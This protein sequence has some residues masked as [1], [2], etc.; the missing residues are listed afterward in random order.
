MNREGP[1]T[2]AE[3]TEQLSPIS[4]LRGR[5]LSFPT[6]A[7]VA[8][9]G[10]LLALVLVRFFD[11]DWGEVW[12]DVRSTRPGPYLLALALY[13]TSFWF[14]GLRWRLI[15]RTAGLE[16][17]SSAEVPRT[18]TMS[19]IILMG[20]F[21]N[22]VAFL[23]LGDA[24]R[25]WA[26][27]RESK[28]GVSASLGTVLAERVQDMAA[29]LVL[30][31]V[32][33]ALLASDPAVEA[34]VSVVIAAVALVAALIAGLIVMRTFGMRLARWLPGRLQ[35]SYAGFQSG[36]LQSFHPR[37]LP[38]QLALGAAGWMLEIARLYYVAEGVGVELSFGVIMFAALANAMLTTIPTPGGFGFVESGLTGLL[39]FFGLDNT[40]AFS[41]TLVD[42]TI[43]W[44]SVVIFGGLLFFYWHFVR[45]RRKSETRPQ[46]LTEPGQ[47]RPASGTERKP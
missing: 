7:A 34:P 40:T 6:L 42:R 39:I 35:K 32:A 44:I 21:A 37:A 12:R 8:I 5:V 38:L 15:A 22:S 9:G 2:P 14:R 46:A 13:Y 30:V 26:L 19:G 17:S 4:R 18:L 10:A 25:G 3:A 45:P 11:I 47:A 20:W 1:Q 36:T 16:K 33:G 27:A 41:V 24:Y 28:S 43:S 23:R 31:L 29:V